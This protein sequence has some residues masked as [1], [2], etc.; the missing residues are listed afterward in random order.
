MEE[1]SLGGAS[2]PAQLVEE[3][4]TNGALVSENEER[5]TLFDDPKYFEGDLATCFADNCQSRMYVCT[6]INRER[7]HELNPHPL[8]QSMMISRNNHGCVHKGCKTYTVC[9]CA[10][11]CACSI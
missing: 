8:T 7:T 5:Q 11:V 3:P 4:K 10:C 9:V 6:K 2:S 1:E